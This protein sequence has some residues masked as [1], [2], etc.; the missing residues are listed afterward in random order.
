MKAAAALSLVLFVAAACAPP[1]GYGGGAPES[2]SPKPALVWHTQVVGGVLEVEI[3]DPNGYYRV[4]R[5]ALVSPNGETY[6]AQETTRETVRDEARPYGGSVGIGIGGGYGSHSGG[7]VGVGLSFPLSGDG[8]GPVVRRTRAR[9]RLPEAIA[10]AGA[11]E[12]WA[13]EIGLTDPAGRAVVARIPGPQP[14]Q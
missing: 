6:P 11:A 4:E 14:A 5:V 3:T 13:I 12:P 10:A 1:G 7:S 9:I 8:Y 2:A